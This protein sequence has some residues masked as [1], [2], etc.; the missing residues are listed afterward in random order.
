MLDD[1]HKLRC[2]FDASDVYFPSVSTGMAENEIL[3]LPE[4]ILLEHDCEQDM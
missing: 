3:T 2:A 1:T 4:R